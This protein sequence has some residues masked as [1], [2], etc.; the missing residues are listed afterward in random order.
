MPAVA[1]FGKRTHG[2]EFI[3]PL[4]ARAC[5]RPEGL[6]AFLDCANERLLGENEIGLEVG[7]QILP[8]AVGV[9]RGACARPPLPPITIECRHC[10][11]GGGPELGFKVE[12]GIV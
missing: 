7:M 11:L 9:A 4:A 3:K 10:L 1:A 6:V 2:V 12:G 8:E 5:A